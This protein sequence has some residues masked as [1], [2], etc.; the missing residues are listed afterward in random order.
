MKKLHCMAWAQNDVYLDACLVMV[1]VF[2]P[3]GQIQSIPAYNADNLAL[4][5]ES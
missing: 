2:P 3:K 1:A 5:T 4:A